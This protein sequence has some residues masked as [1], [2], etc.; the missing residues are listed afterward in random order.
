MN[1]SL[2]TKEKKAAIKTVESWDLFQTI[3]TT[4]KISKSSVKRRTVCFVKNLPENPFLA[5]K[6]R[7]G[8]LFKIFSDTLLSLKRKLSRPL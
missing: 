6:P 2:S 5:T 3:I 4:L 8:H 1:K 7:S